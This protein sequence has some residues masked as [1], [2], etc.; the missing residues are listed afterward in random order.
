M[1]RQAPG[2]G[3]NRFMSIF[4]LLVAIVFLIAGCGGGAGTG[5]SEGS[6]GTGPTNASNPAPVVSALSPTSEVVGTTPAVVTITGTGFVEGSTVQWN[7]SSRTATYVSATELQ[8]TPAATD[9]A[10]AGTAQIAVVNSTPGGGTS[11][12]ATFTVNNPA[13]AVAALS[14]NILLTMSSGSPITVSG[15][16]FV[17]TSTVMWN[18]TARTTTFVNATALQIT[19]TAADLSG[20]GTAQITVVN[21]GPGGGTSSA[22][23]FN[24]NNPAPAVSGISP[25]SVT[26]ISSGSV[27]TVTGSGFLPTSAVMWNGTAHPSTYVN[28]TQLQLTVAAADVAAVGSAQIT[29]VNGGPSGGTTPNSPVSIVYPV[30]AINTVSP[31][32]VA[33]GSTPPTLSISGLG[34]APN[35]VVQI[36]GVSRTTTYV[37]GGLLTTLLTAGDLAS[38]GILKIII[39]TIG[40]G[41][42]SS[43]S[44]NCTVQNYATPV[45]SQVSPTS[46]VVNS[47]DTAVGIYGTGLT[48]ASTVQVNGTTVS[49]TLLQQPIFTYPIISYGPPF[50]NITIPAAEL[51]SLNTLSITVSNPGTVVSNA[52]TINVVGAPTPTLSQISPTSGALGSSVALTLYGTNFSASSVVQWNGLAVPTTYNSTSYLTATVPASDVQTL[53]NIS[54]TV[55]TPAPG[56]GVTSSQMFTVYLGLPANDL[57]YSA[58]TQ[59]LYAS[60]PSSG[61]STYGNSIVPIDPNTGVLGTP[62]YVGSEPG[63]VGLSSD[64]NSLWVALNGTAA[65]RQVNLTTQTAGLQFGTGVSSNYYYSGSQAPVQE[66]AVMPGTPNTI[67]VLTPSTTQSYNSVVTI[68]DSG[69]ARPN[70]ADAFSFC[71]TAITG[72]A[73]DPTGANL[74]LAG[75]GYGKATV[76]STGLTGQVELNNN[77]TS[78]DLK[79]DSGRAYLTSGIVLDAD[80]GLQVGILAGLNQ[81]AAP[82]VVPDSSVGSAFALLPNY[83]NPNEINAYDLSTYVL[84]GSIPFNP[85]PNYYT[86]NPSRLTRWGQNGVA[87]TTGTQIYILQSPV[88]RDL[89]QSLADLSVS[90]TAPTV[91]TTGTNWN[92]AITVSNASNTQSVVAATPAILTDNLPQGVQVQSTT[93]SQGTCSIGAVV[94]C[95]LGTLNPGASATVQI[96]VTPLADGMLTNT[97]TVSAP[98][99]DPD[100]TNN[101]VSSTTTVTGSTYS[102]TPSITSISPSFVPAGSPAQTLTVNGAGFTSGSTVQFNGAALSTTFVNSTQLTANVPMNDVA[103]LSWA[104]INVSTPTPG[105]GNSGSLPFSVYKTISLDVNRMIF[106]PYK[107]KLYGT[108]PSTATQ[109]T[110]NS[111]VAIDP[112]SGTLGTPLNVGSEPTPLAESSDGKDLYIG[113]TGSKSLTSVNLT[114]MA[115]GPTIPLLFT[116]NN[117]TSQYPAFDLAVNPGNDNLV[118]VSTES[119]PGIALMDISGSTGTVRPQ[120]AVVSNIS[121]PVFAN[122]SLLYALGAGSLYRYN[123]SA[124]GLTADNT[125]GYPLDNSGG[126]GLGFVLDNGLLFGNNGGVSDP[127]TTPP[128]LLGEF[129]VSSALGS[130][131]VTPEVAA[132]DLT[133][134]RAFFLGENFAGNSNALL[135]S[136]DTTRYR[137]LSSGTITGGSAG[138]DLVRWG[139]D[140]LAWHSVV[141][142]QY[143]NATPGSGV[144]YIMRGPFVLPEWATV[145]PVATATAVAPTSTTHGTGNILLTVMGSNFVPGAVVKWNGAERSTTFVDAGHLTVAI[146]ASDV[147]AAG[148]AS[149]TVNNPNAT[150]SGAVTFT[151]N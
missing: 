131:S 148:T 65:I 1:K 69:V 55:S 51:T 64:G 119:S 140:G 17:S 41:G 107:Q 9:L 74:Y 14:P 82:A 71:C 79:V 151:I 105:G 93:T 116:I 100:T 21:G 25:N 46:I 31:A 49:S 61:G 108:L 114:T 106:D 6:T 32:T 101:S 76:G 73:F 33:P 70:T 50:L 146:P 132:P 48:S 133:L 121:N 12:A 95:D 128:T 134:G 81:Y 27:V 3:L 147:S 89:S 137:L 91:G 11:S 149:L 10:S 115:Q 68:Y 83:S 67:A 120:T 135:L 15:T 142:G 54:V 123:I 141:T 90:V 127:T 37:N 72:I 98:E 57:V 86:Q 80:T 53:G 24:V 118:A 78:N 18:G 94:T 26:T 92:Y 66:I 45:L 38:P 47:P 36:N 22:A 143:S 52:E 145:N 5:S 16:G 30:P 58:S 150:D 136:Y 77:V 112:F 85:P 110:G 88:V 97:V 56:G 60:V 35:S 59:L 20:A 99:G 42:G 117:S 122:A 144:V 111:L 130:Q 34:F 39:I 43:G 4:T 138:E 109:A 62:I 102:V 103:T 126:F 29:V 129:T 7:S 75:G 19:P 125:S 28:S 8:I 104:W 139:R 124:N 40:P 23:T 87:F 84:K 113:L 13:P 63:R 44:S 2:Q 96:T